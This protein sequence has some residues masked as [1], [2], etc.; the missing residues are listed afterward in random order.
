MSTHALLIHQAFAGPNDPGGTRHYELGYRFVKSGNVFSVVASR[1]SYLTGSQSGDVYEE[2]VQ[3]LTIRRAYAL[4]TL[5]RSFVWRVASFL[6]FMASSFREGC[7]AGSPD[8]I[9]GTTPPIFQALSAWLLAKL[10]DKPFLLEVRDLWPE[11]AIDMG[12]LKGR[13][14]IAIARML[15]SFLYA[16]ATHILVNSPAYRDYL[17]DRGIPADKISFIPNG[18]DPSMFDP[19]ARGDQFR[20]ELQL[21]DKFVVTYAG[22]LG[23]ANDIPTII[24]AAD[25]LRNRD[26]IH[27]LLIGDGKE[28]T[29]LE[30]QTNALKLT[31][32]TF[33]GTRPKT[34]MPTVLA[35][36]D[37]C[38]ATLR[39]IPMFRTT[40]PNKVFDYMAAG[41]PVILGIDGVIREVVEAADAG[42]FVQPGS[43][44]QLANAVTQLADDRA[45]AES[46]GRS[47]REYI[48][49]HF[50]RDDHADAFVTLLTQLAK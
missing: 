41:R 7:N 22:A 26:D 15:E 46:M 34:M 18:S 29:N 35:A 27:F 8:V 16:Q 42:M 20:H 38:L 2:P 37:A 13:L 30:Q 19:A 6:S 31:N 47:G 50:N 14:P 24:R 11:F 25:R 4:P 40:Y 23:I 48:T 17:L 43:D 1:Q 5:H 3:D 12:V 45:S 44:E 39:D 36:S 33:A 21:A 49:T 28:R 10:R 32:I 9:M